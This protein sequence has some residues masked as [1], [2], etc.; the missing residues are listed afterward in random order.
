[1]RSI[2]LG[3]RSASPEG[4]SEVLALQTVHL[5]NHLYGSDE[6]SAL[7]HAKG[8][9]QPFSADTKLMPIFKKLVEAR[10]TLT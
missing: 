8:F 1:M 3:L 5:S 6:Y 2:Y 10:D 7:D 9:T 4:L